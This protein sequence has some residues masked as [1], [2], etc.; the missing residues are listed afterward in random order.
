MKLSMTDRN[1]IPN[2]TVSQKTQIV[3]GNYHDDGKSGEVAILL[4]APLFRIPERVRAAAKLY[5]EGRVKYI[6]ASGGVEWETDDG[7]ISEAMYMVKMLNELGVPDQAIIIENEARTTRENMIYSTLQMCRKIKL[8][9]INRV[10]IVTSPS[11][12]RRSLIHGKML[13]P[14]TVEVSGY[15]AESETDSRECWFNFPEIAECV[16]KE[17]GWLKGLVTNEKVEDIEY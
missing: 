5:F 3:Y 8:S 6:I 10:I 7:K 13:L 17:L 12:I 14:R 4:G 9:K 16:E 11:H 2:L 15:A 1:S